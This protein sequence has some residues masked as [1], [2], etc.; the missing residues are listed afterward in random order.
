MNIQS[1]TSCLQPTMSDYEDWIV[2]RRE[3]SDIYSPARN[4]QQRNIEYCMNYY[5]H[6]MGNRPTQTS[7]PVHLTQTGNSQRD[8]K[9]NES[10]LARRNSTKNTKLK[11]KPSIKNCS[12]TIS[13]SDLYTM[14]DDDDQSSELSM[15]SCRKCT[16]D[17][18]LED[19]VCAACG[20]SR[21]SSIGDIDIPRMFRCTKVQEMIE[22][23]DKD[24]K[25]ENLNKP[26][27]YEYVELDKVFKEN[28]R[29]SKIEDDDTEQNPSILA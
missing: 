26:K 7:F 17:N 5:S 18:P 29:L 13:I 3:L 4:F 1:E 2:K 27:E 8:S 22:K 16:L 24:K 23:V 9:H 12:Q 6:A 19:Q 21:L 28:K 14:A 20:G 10:K 15:W 11:D 25:Q